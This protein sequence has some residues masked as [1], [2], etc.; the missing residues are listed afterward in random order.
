MLKKPRY[1]NRPGE[2]KQNFKIPQTP[3]SEIGRLPRGIM[4]IILKVDIIIFFFI[5]MLIFGVIREIKI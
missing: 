5:F 4:A 1:L 2:E 3:N